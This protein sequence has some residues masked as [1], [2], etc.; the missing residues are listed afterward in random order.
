MTGKGERQLYHVGW[1]AHFKYS[2]GRSHF[3]SL[4]TLTLMVDYV[5]SLHLYVSRDVHATGTI[6]CNIKSSDSPRLSKL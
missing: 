3:E 1:R 4:S 5:D 6:A 2:K